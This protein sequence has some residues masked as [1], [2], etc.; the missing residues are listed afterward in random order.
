MRKPEVNFELGEVGEKEVRALFEKALFG[1]SHRLMGRAD[2]GRDLYLQFSSTSPSRMPLDFLVQVKTGSS[3]VEDCGGHWRIRSIDERR[4]NEWR[5][6]ATPVVLVWLNTDLDED[7]TAYWKLINRNTSREHLYVS[8]HS[9]VCPITR[10]ELALRLEQ[11]LEPAEI[12]HRYRLLPVGLNVGVRPRAKSF[13]KDVLMKC[14]PV[15]PRLGPIRFTWRGWRHI[16]NQKRDPRSIFTSLQL[17]P[18]I[19]QLIERPGQLFGLRRLG[20]QR[21]GKFIS[22]RK[23]IALEYPG[24]PLMH[25]TPARIV[26]VLR[27]RIIYPA[28]WRTGILRERDVVREVTFESIYEKLR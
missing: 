7:K 13:Y 21:R 19:T 10:F 14:S 11:L 16:T 12:R 4:F 6:S 24:V 20:S 9:H 18:I 22:D 23:L 15:N 27:E 8:K 26:M 17:L 25:R 5:K 28:R 1:H 2:L 3:H